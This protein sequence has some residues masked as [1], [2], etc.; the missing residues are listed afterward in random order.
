ML[1]LM[2]V[3]IG[4]LELGD[5]AKGAGSGTDGR[6]ERKT[7]SRRCAAARRYTNRRRGIQETPNSGK[8][9]LRHHAA[10]A[11]GLPFASDRGEKRKGGKSRAIGISGLGRFFL[12]FPDLFLAHFL[13][14]PGL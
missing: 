4:P 11:K 13:I 14:Q 7:G 1:R 8:F 9:G 2:R 10:G 12:F 5:L 6:R 3:A